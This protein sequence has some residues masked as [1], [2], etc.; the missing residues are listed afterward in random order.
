M[1]VNSTTK[2]PEQLNGCCCMQSLLELFR[3]KHNQQQVV[4]CLY[5]YH[6]EA[7]ET[8]ASFGIFSI[9][10]LTSLNPLPFWRSSPTPLTGC[11]FSSLGYEPVYG[12]DFFFIF[13]FVSTVITCWCR[14]AK[15]TKIGSDCLGTQK[16][17]TFI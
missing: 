7:D 17:S 1:V 5:I 6:L 15:F 3:G 16:R 9:V 13:V 8:A 11:L 10:L 4:S 12:S 2:I 14:E